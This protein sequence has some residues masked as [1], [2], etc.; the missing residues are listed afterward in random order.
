[1]LTI[2]LV[3]STKKNKFLGPNLGCGCQRWAGVRRANGHEAATA[4]CAPWQISPT[5]SDA[6]SSCTVHRMPLDTR[7]PSRREVCRTVPQ[8]RSSL[9]AFTVVLA[10]FCYPFPPDTMYDVPQLFKLLTLR[11]QRPWIYIIL[12]WAS[13]CTY[14][15]RPL[16]FVLIWI[17]LNIF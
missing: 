9:P 8:P 11:R 10:S 17:C 5:D 14:S 6:T 7:I 16:L 13:V 2:S 12:K 3:R 15:F 1:M 4:H